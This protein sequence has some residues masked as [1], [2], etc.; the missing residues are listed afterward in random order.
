MSKTKYKIIIIVLIVIILILIPLVV[1]DYIF[2]YNYDEWFRQYL[3]NDKYLILVKEKDR[4]ENWVGNRVINV[5]IKNTENNN[6]IAHFNTTID[7]KGSTL[8]SDNYLLESNQQYI[9]LKFFNADG[10]LSGAY[11]FYYEDYGK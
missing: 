4:S 2:N 1:I 6:V 9:L 5:Y 10:S 3:N 7:N 8:E 11:R